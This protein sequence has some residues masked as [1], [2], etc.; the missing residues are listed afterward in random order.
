MFCLYEYLCSMCMQFP[1]RPEEGIRFPGTGVN[2]WLWVTTTWVLVLLILQEQPVLLA[3]E[4]SLQPAC[5]PFLSIQSYG[6]KY[7]HSEGPVFSKHLDSDTSGRDNTFD[8]LGFCLAS[9]RKAFY[10]WSFHVSTPYWLLNILVAHSQGSGPIFSCSVI[11]IPSEVVIRH[12]ND[13]SPHIPKA[14]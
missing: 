14:N 7:I 9:W 2:R 6:I 4:P 3:T 5:W 10:F 11:I 12:L 13:I 1:K 8:S